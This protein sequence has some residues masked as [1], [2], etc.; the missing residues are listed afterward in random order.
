MSNWSW[1]GAGGGA[2][3]GATMGTQV[4]PGWGTVIGG[5]GGAIMGG[6]TTEDEPEEVKAEPMLPDWLMDLRKNLPAEFEKLRGLSPLETTGGALLTQLLGQPVGAETGL[7]GAVS[8]Q[9]LKTLKGEYDP[10]T[11]PY[12]GS[13]RRGIEKEGEV[14]RAQIRRSAQKA[15]MLQAT[16]RLMKEARLEDLMLGAKGDVLARLFETERG[17][18]LEAVRPAMEMME[19]GETQPLRRISAAYGYGGLP[20]SIEEKI[21]AGK[22]GVAGMGVPYGI[23]TLYGPSSGENMLGAGADVLKA[24]LA[25]GGKFGTGAKP[26]EDVK[27]PTG[28]PSVN[29]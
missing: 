14:G 9:L 19:L 11:S 18:G 29:V 8:E 15:G 17:R 13:L 23:E 20:R 22:M 16:P 21:L 28:G 3:S 12:Y 5:V 7:G 26:K 25:G 10:Y 27:K 1:Q 6:L 2:M 24:Y 4:M